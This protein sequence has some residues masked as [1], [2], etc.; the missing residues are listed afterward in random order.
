[1]YGETELSFRPA[2]LRSATDDL[3]V[4]AWMSCQCIHVYI[5]IGIFMRA[6]VLHA[7]NVVWRLHLV[8]T[9]MPWAVSSHVVV[10][11]A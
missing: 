1:M 2:L 4:Y 5:D 10:G 11:G 9:Y 7:L 6:N 8:C 3:D